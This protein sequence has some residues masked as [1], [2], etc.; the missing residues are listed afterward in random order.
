MNKHTTIIMLI[1]ILLQT[2][3]LSQF[4]LEIVG[5]SSARRSQIISTIEINMNH[6]NICV[7]EGI[8]ISNED[9]VINEINADWTNEYTR[10]RNYLTIVGPEFVAK[11]GLGF[12]KKRALQL[13]PLNRIMEKDVSGVVLKF[14]L[15]IIICCY[16][17]KEWELCWCSRGGGEVISIDDFWNRGTFYYKSL[18]VMN[19]YLFLCPNRSVWKI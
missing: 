4:F 10:A 5:E 11:V 19:D 7:M 17:H 12:D 2:Y 13:T 18:V 6:N 1:T 8:I 15:F 16:K 3:V 9:N 14:N